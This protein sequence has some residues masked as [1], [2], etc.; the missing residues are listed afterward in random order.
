[1]TRRIAAFVTV[2]GLGFIVQL[3]ALQWFTRAGW[4]PIVATA[5]AV[6]LA[7]LHNFCWHERWTWVDRTPRGQDR[8]SRLSRYHAATSIT[9]VGNVIATLVFAEAG[10]GLVAANILAVGT[11]SAVNFVASDQWTFRPKRTVRVP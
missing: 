9:A 1:M 4:E 5:A 2:G 6:E 11:M 7:V 10:I 8:W 3:A